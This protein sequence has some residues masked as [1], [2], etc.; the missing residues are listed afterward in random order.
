MPSVENSE[1]GSIMPKWMP[2]ENPVDG[3]VALG[4]GTRK[5]HEDMLDALLSDPNVD[6]VLGIILPVPNADFADE[7]E[8]YMNLLQKH[9]DKPMFNFFIGDD[10]KE[11]WLK[12]T[13]DLHIPN[14]TDARSAIRALRR[15]YA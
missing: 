8:M 13:D 7:R 14:F 6:M 10:V 9:P 5:C 4:V 3:W 1:I 15:R 2:V 11:R 12:E